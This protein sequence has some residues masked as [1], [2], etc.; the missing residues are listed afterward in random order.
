MYCP[1]CNTQIDDNLN[2]C[3]N[4]G[5]NLK[6]LSNES[7]QEESTVPGSTNS[8]QQ[9]PINT[10][11]YQQPPG[12]NASY[13]QPPPGNP[14]YQQPPAGN[15]YYQQPPPGNPYYHQPPGG[16]QPNPNYGQP[17]IRPV[18][19]TLIAIYEIIFGVIL[20]FLGLILFS[21]GNNPTVQINDAV[22]GTSYAS[23][24][25]VLGIIVILWGLLGII[26]AILFLQ[27]KNSGYIMSL[28]FLIS[29]GVVM[30]SLYLI[31]L[32]A[33]IVSLVYFFSNQNFKNTFN[34]MKYNRR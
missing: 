15:Q 8:Y 30:F 2:F 17:V 22:G 21:V 28:I 34:Y 12:F 18:G 16:F 23:A 10:P 32:I 4:C 33:M 3:S 20:V 14:Y 13:Q 25:F 1:N 27:W 31:P 9:P 24:F 5:T 11:A 26:G 7:A 6:K 19:I 29:T